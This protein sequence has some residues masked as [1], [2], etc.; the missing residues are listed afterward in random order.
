MKSRMILLSMA[1]LLLLA[2]AAGAQVSPGHDLSWHVIAAG[3]AGMA[4]SGHSANG[5][6]GQLAIGPAVGE[7]HALAA[8][9]W[10]GLG[11]QLYAIYLPLIVRNS[12]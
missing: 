6:L 5:T 9:Y 2:G 4:S 10:H 11:G 12:P 8:G 3:G 7:P 1:V